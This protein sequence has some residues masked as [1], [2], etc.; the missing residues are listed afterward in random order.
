MC[1]SPRAQA[2]AQI[3]SCAGNAMAKE[4]FLRAISTA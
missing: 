3:V 4:S 1:M 2:S